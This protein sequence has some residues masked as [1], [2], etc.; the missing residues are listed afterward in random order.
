M[1]EE[2][3]ATEPHEFTTDLCADDRRETLKK[4]YL[5][6]HEARGRTPQLDASML[7]SMDQT[8][9]DVNYCMEHMDKD[10]R[11]AFGQVLRALTKEKLAIINAEEA[12][13]VKKG[14]SGGS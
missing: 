14:S 2:A 3:P 12:K 4:A 11:P 1:Q 13:T 6:T 9:L 7:D 5:E 8:S 10:L